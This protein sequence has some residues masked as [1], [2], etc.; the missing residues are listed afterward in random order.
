MT[1]APERTRPGTGRAALPQ[2]RRDGGAWL[3]ALVLAAR[4]TAYG[5]IGVEL[6]MLVLW[7]T[8]AHSG[9]SATAT[10]RLGLVFWSA[11]HHATVHVG[12]TS[13]GVAPYGLT[14]I[15]A[16]LL[17]RGTRT[18]LAS[19]DRVEPAAFVP[20]LAVCY[21]VLCTAVALAARSPAVR[22]EPAE[23]FVGGAILA[24][25]AAG[26]AA[27]R[28]HG[29]PRRLPPRAA[30]VLLGAARAVAVW[31]AAGLVLALVAV[32]AAHHELA[33]T[34]QALHPGASGMAGLV[35]LDL[36]VAPHL[37]VYGGSLLTGPGFGVGA[38]TSVSLAGSHLGAVPALP[39][40][41]ALPTS[42]PFPAFLLV[43]LLVPVAAGVV[44]GLRALRTARADWR[45]RAE[46][47][48]ATGA[49]GGVALASIAWLADGSAGPGR[50]AVSGPSPWQVG[51]AGGGEM[52]AG[53]L[54][55]LAVMAL[56]A[57][58]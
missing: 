15:P 28:V 17:Y 16:A 35:L 36:L 5:L 13:L 19:D 11:A 10:L 48:L 12:S 57:R 51:L 44:G 39:V 45:D 27:L 32:G 33:A 31:L 37:A 40:L 9:S 18:L 25:A 2:V 26:A 24:L 1:Q 29:R 49:A 55:V 53:G 52:L 14:V 47:V 46:R 34:A 4:T 3:P 50:L 8:A 20:A 41:A 38:H 6:I 7:A 58:R 56:R 21:G 23:A 30:E 54:L 42:G 22:P 43:L